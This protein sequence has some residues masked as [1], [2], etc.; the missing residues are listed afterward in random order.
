MSKQPFSKVKKIC[1]ISNAPISQNPRVV[2]E[3]DVL[4]SAGYDVVVIF[5]QH[6]EWTRSLD[7]EILERSKWRAICLRFYQKGILRRAFCLFLATRLHF[8][9][10]LSRLFFLFPFAELAHSRLYVEQLLTALYEKADLY[11]GH[12]PQSLPVAA[13]AARLRGARCAFDSEDLHTGEFAKSEMHT[14]SYRLVEYNETKYLPQCDYVSTP[15][16]L[17]AEAL[18]SHY[19]IN[20]PL[21]IHNVF[22]LTERYNLDGQI[23]DRK[24]N[25]LSLYWYSQIIGEDRG[26]QDVIKAAGLLKGEV[27]I[28]LRGSVTEE[29]KNKFLT[30][31]QK[32]GVEKNLYFHHPVPPT[33][34]LS[35]AVEHD[36]GLA[37][38]QPNTLNH[39][40][41]VSNK[42]FVYLLA[43]LA[44]AA[45][46]I[47]SQRYIMSTCPDVG[48]LYPPGDYQTLADHIKLWIE[49]HERLKSCK[50]AALEA[51]RKR[52][53]WEIEGK[54]LLDK[55]KDIA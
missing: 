55:I 50:Q 10:W 5:G 46:D 35:R 30:L 28:H 16:P 2:K 6:D 13:M 34:L 53:N 31:A 4:S 1:I 21:V 11:I 41:T 44:I 45:T 27:Q 42:L 18:A 19:K 20:Q 47:P 43:G 17:I 49:N 22:P 14:L 51:A 9:Q 12:N 33:E 48:F 29:V 8:F 39:R 52:W 3:A 25:V 7:T 15:S 54:A 36:I 23:K 37:L 40:L 26:I 32:Y 38:E 24:R